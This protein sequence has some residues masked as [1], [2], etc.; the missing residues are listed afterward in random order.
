MADQPAHVIDEGDQIGL[1]VFAVDADRGAVHDIGLPELVGEFGLEAAPIH[2]GMFGALHQSLALE[3]SPDGAF[4]QVLFGVD[5]APLLSGANESL[6]GDARHLAAH[7]DKRQGGL[8]IERPSLTAIASAMRIECFE[9][10]AA[11]L[12]GA[13][14]RADGGRGKTGA[15]GERNLP[16]AGALLLQKP[17][18]LSPMKLARADKIADH[19]ET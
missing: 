8:W 13:N 16:V 10:L 9:P 18:A 19:P 5:H 3:Q 12:V 7:P 15:M 11:F 17:R 1:A 2:G 6:Y 4:G 14:P